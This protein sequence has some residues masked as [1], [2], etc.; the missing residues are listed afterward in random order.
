MLIKRTSGLTG[1]EHELDIDVE[2]EQ[3]AAWEGGMLI[4]EAMPHLSADDREFIM[5]GVTP[6]EW[7][8][9]FGDCHE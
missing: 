4:Q 2:P 7:D 9:Q 5:T 6:K 3:L 1:I 8:E